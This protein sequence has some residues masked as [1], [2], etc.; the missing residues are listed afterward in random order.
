MNELV[1]HRFGYVIRRD[2]YKPEKLSR[3]FQPRCSCGA[4]SDTWYRT[5]RHAEVTWF[6]RH[7]GAVESAKANELTLF[8]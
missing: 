5:V 8:P 2:I 6:E 3:S 7:I 4:K 1:G